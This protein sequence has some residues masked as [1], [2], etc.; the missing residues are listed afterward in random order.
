ML[1]NWL[2][3][4]NFLT[5]CESTQGKAADRLQ[6]SHTFRERRGGHE[7]SQSIGELSC[8]YLLVLVLIR[9]LEGVLGILL[10]MVLLVFKVVVDI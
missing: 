2:S 3:T 5:K 8:A 4:H 10:S 7:L 1:V 6:N 9:F